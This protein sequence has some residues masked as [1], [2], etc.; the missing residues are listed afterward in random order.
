M[1][2]K[3][4]TMSGADA[5][6]IG[7]VPGQRYGEGVEQQAMQQAM[8]A[9]DTAGTV[10]PGGNSTVPAPTVTGPM[11]VNPEQ[12][13]GFLQQHNPKLL[14][15]TQN[16]DQPVTAGMQL[17]PGPGP[18]ATQVPLSRYLANLAADTGN[19][20]WKRLAERAGLR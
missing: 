13:G 14:G 7:S 11:Q 8:P 10:G 4:K 9:P 2:R 17:G 18:Q 16:P 5:Q 15:G 20:K 19:P 3:R 12:V 1:P 6:D